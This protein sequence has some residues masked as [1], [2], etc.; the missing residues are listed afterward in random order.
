MIQLET[1]KRNFIMA[2]DNS[3]KVA[4]LREV[5]LLVKDAVDYRNGACRSNEM[6]GAVLDKRILER[7][8]NVL[9]S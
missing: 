5:L 4:E 2:D 6:V 7:M 3:N 8:D 9:S 1:T